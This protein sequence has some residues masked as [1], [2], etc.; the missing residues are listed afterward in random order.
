MIIAFNFSVD[1]ACLML[2]YFLHPSREPRMLQVLSWSEQSHLPLYLLNTELFSLAWEFMAGDLCPVIGS[3]GNCFVRHLPS[4]SPLSGGASLWCNFS[5]QDRRGSSTLALK[6]EVN[7]W[8]GIKLSTALLPPGQRL[9]CVTPHTVCKTFEGCPH[10]HVWC[11]L[12]SEALRILISLPGFGARHTVSFGFSC[13]KTVPGGN[14][15]RK[16]LTLSI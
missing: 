3:C 16:Q 9:K 15:A 4:Y 2:V 6:G 11:Q 13:I 8:M 10:F 1:N 14:T 5:C 7:L 12:G